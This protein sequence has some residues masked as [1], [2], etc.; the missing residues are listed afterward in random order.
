MKEQVGTRKQGFEFILSFKGLPAPGLNKFLMYL[1]YA[2]FYIL[3]DDNI[4]SA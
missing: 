4:I 3:I 1:V 2:K